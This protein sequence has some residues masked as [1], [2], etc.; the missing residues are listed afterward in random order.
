[1][2]RFVSSLYLFLLA[3]N[4]L[5]AA[6]TRTEDDQQAKER[7]FQIE[8][9]VFA[10]TDK[11]GL[12]AENWPDDA[13]VPDVKNAIDFL[14]PP[15]AIKQTEK[16]PADTVDADK[17]K[18]VL[19]A[20]EVKGQV[21]TEDFSLSPVNTEQ[22]TDQVPFE[23]KT[24]ELPFIALTSP[25]FI[26]SPHAKVI[27]RSRKYRLIRHITWHQPVF[28]KAKSIPIR[29]FG[30]EDFA[31]RFDDDGYPLLNLPQHD[32]VSESTANEASAQ[33]NLLNTNSADGTHSIPENSL[34]PNLDNQDLQKIDVSN[35]LTLLTADE[36]RVIDKQVESDK[37]PTESLPDTGLPEF[38]KPSRH[39]WQLDGLFTVYVKRY[40]HVKFD[41]AYKNSSMKEVDE[42]QFASFT[43]FAFPQMD[44]NK[45]IEDTQNDQQQT[46]NLDSQNELPAHLNW[47]DIGD[48][49]LL[50]FTEPKNGQKLQLEFLK[51][52]LMH[53]K[54]RVR[55]KEI[56]YFDHPL[57]GVVM[58]ITPYQ[59]EPVEE[60]LEK[61]TEEDSV[62]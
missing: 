9:I 20:T 50:A 52:Y 44:T 34:S 7:W 2:L 56:H 31:D 37:K 3:S 12:T 59:P 55:S 57:F 8:L 42:N 60:D 21:A 5:W 40:L 24:C 53:Q 51:P 19:P 45:T 49:N 18:T 23:F 54:R 27:Q 39:N 46:T 33:N 36:A 62:N 1:M 25:D 28:S 32:D 13:V 38:E 10:R 26:L 30:G 47:N 41:L 6:D 17:A 15:P 35:N 11:S 58:L 22:T 43:D 29:I 14:T 48:E 61:E 4:T 16:E